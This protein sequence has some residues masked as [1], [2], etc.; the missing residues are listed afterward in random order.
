[1]GFIGM[2]MCQFAS[3]LGVIYTTPDTASMWAPLIPVVVAILAILL[4]TEPLPKIKTKIG[5]AK[6]FGILLAAGGA[7]VM[8]YANR[9]GRSVNGDD[10]AKPKPYGYL[11]L[12][13]SVFSSGVW[14]VM[15][16][17]YFQ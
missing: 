1:M 5:S 9:N 4:R 11:F 8:T 2:F 16:K 14:I 7:F 6:I 13:I 12:L 15:Q 3:I 10:L 17:I